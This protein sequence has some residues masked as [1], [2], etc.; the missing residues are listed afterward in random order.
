MDNPTININVTNG[1]GESRFDGGLLQLVGWT[2]LGLLITVCTLGIC[3]PWA[4]C[5]V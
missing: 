1:S 3:L 2:L 4:Y 5:M